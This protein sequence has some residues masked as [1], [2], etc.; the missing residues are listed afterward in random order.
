[1]SLRVLIS[2]VA[3]IGFV[4][5][6]QSAEPTMAQRAAEFAI[7]TCYR[8]L[9]DVS[10]VRSFAR[11]MGWGGL[12]PDLLNIFK[13]VEGGADFTGWRVSH[14]GQLFFVG[15]NVGVFRGKTANICSV[16]ANQPPDAVRS[17][18]LSAL[19]TRSLTVDKDAM[20]IMEVYEL[21]DHPSVDTA[22]MTITRLSD[23]AAPVSVAFMGLR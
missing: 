9:D 5:P 13:P 18:L 1:M 3:F 8:A 7:G 23:G 14:E 20:Q 17:A 21:V 6:S 22:F 11:L 10:R 12:S 16:V 2:L 4:L 15:V 19:K